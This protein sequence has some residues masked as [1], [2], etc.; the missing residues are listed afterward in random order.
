MADVKVLIIDQDTPSISDLENRLQALGHQV[1]AVTRFI[2]D[3]EKQISFNQPQIIFFNAPSGWGNKIFQTIED[4]NS[5]GIPIILVLNEADRKI[6]EADPTQPCCDL[7]TKPIID[8]EIQTTIRFALYRQKSKKEILEQELQ[9]RAILHSTGDGLITFDVHGNILHM[10]AVAEMLTEWSND[11]SKGKQL[12]EV[13]KIIDSKKQSPIEISELLRMRLKTGPLSEFDIT[14]ISREGNPI[15]VRARLSPLRDPAEN[16]KGGVIAFGN[17]SELTRAIEQI[18]LHS[19]R[20]EVLLGIIA[21]LNSKLDLDDVL[22]SLLQETTKIMEASGAVVVLMDADGETFQVVATYSQD[23][24]LHRYKGLKFQLEKQ[25]RYTLIDDLNP[26]RVFSDI[27][28]PALQPYHDLLV[29][30]NISTLA[31]AELQYENHLLGAMFIINTGDSREYTDDELSFLKGLADQASLAITNAQLFENVRNSRFRLQYL[32]KRLVEVQ[33]AERKAM[34]RELHDQIGQMLTGLQFS[35]ESGKRKA[36][37]DT[38]T[39]FNDAQEIVSDLIRQVREL[40]LRLLPSMLDDM[41]LFPTLQWH[42]EQYT[43]QTGI[44]VYFSQDGL[45]DQRLPQNIEITAYRI[46]QEGLTN[47]ARHAQVDSVNVEINVSDSVVHLKISDS[48]KGFDPERTV[49]AR[50]TFGLIGMRERT[51]LVGGELTVKSAPGKGTSL[52]AHLPL[53]NHIERRKYAR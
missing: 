51:T 49:I 50:K 12:S 31:L 29:K 23:D 42:F 16:L 8:A 6:L 33:E 17:I 18:R 4:L 45:E 20:A 41:G 39:I 27:Q 43:N 21:K 3:A 19:H 32:S 5:F 26:V 44:Q 2:N 38:K 1:S 24:H 34:A 28:D 22:I 40:S 46:I 30:E 37:G 47:T 35:L 11:A 10:N 7:V 48:G 36:S 52:V 9:I 14:L 25:K 13:L 15:P 53:D